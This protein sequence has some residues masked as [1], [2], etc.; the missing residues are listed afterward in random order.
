MGLP[1]T[2]SKI[3]GDFSQKSHN[4]PTLPGFPLELG[5]GEPTR[6]VKKLE[7]WGYK[8]GEKVFR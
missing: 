5:I 6:G 4:F 8:M 7:W 2:V 3:E 1:R